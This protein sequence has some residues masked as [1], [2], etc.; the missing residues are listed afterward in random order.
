MN[1][2]RRR[3]LHLAVGAAALPVVPRIAFAQAYPTR[4]VRNPSAEPAA[5]AI[6]CTPTGVDRS[7]LIISH[8]KRV[9]IRRR[10]LERNRRAQSVSTDL[11]PITALQDQDGQRWRSLQPPISRAHTGLRVLRG[12]SFWGSHNVKSQSG[13]IWTNEGEILPS[14]FSE[15]TG[16]AVEERNAAESGRIATFPVGTGRS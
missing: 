13:L 14:P 2:P 6:R 8:H 12:Q 16:I 3:F 4:P 11:Q 7:G 5:T 9:P 10:P 1:L 15:T